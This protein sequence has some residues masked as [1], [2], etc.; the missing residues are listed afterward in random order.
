LVLSSEDAKSDF[1]KFY[2]ESE[3]T[4]KVIPFATTTGKFEQIDTSAIF[5]KY[6]IS[7][8]Y[9]FSPNQFWAHKNHIILLKAINLLKKKRL[10]YQVVFTGK[11]NDYRNANYME[12][13]KKYIA[14]NNIADTIRFLGFIDRADQLKLMKESIAVIQPS[15]FEGWSTVVEDA[16]AMNQ[17]LILS[18]LNVHKEQCGKNALYF[19]PYDESLLAEKMELA[20][21][22]KK[23]IYNYDYENNI[24][25][26][27]LRIADL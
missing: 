22:G 7:K 25:E 27:G 23:I 3:C 4:I 2:P 9:F 5:K 10:E 14:E 19:D 15:L 21:N 8:P 12:E 26:F 24:K 6:N 16:K 20:L 18:S 11:E 13:L 17:L 1:L